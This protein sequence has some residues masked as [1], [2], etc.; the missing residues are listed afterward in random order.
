MSHSL[1]IDIRE[2]L[3]AYLASEISL[4]EFEDWFFSEIW[5]VDQVDDLDLLS[6]V[7]GIKLRL[8]EFSHGDWTEDELYSLLMLVTGRLFYDK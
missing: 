3:A 4:G 6:L 7:Y 1:D 2:R 8:A 5:D